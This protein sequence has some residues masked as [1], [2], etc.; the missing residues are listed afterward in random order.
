MMFSV[1]RLLQD[2]HQSEPDPVHDL[3]GW[4]HQRL[5]LRS[6]ARTTGHP[7]SQLRPHPADGSG[8]DPQQWKPL[9]HRHLQVC[10]SRL[11]LCPG[12]GQSEL[13]RPKQNLWVQ[14]S[15]EHH[16]RHAE[17]TWMYFLSKHNKSLLSSKFCSISSKVV[18][19]SAIIIHMYKIC[20]HFLIVILVNA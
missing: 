7:P 17:K 16:Q 20:L 5:L 15:G 3:G 6:L 1:G 12:C 11:H 10:G 14:S 13:S 9:L 19:W 8:L 18:N 2:F 4:V